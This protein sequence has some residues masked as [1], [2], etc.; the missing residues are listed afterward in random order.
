MRDYIGPMMLLSLIAM[1]LFVVSQCSKEQIH[2]KAYAICLEAKYK[3]YA[4]EGCEG[5]VG[6]VDGKEL[7]TIGDQDGI[8]YYIP[9]NKPQMKQ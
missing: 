9:R 6:I 5:S 1:I 8:Y 4:L 3:G 2:A 7:P